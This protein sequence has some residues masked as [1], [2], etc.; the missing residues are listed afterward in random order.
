MPQHL[1][2]AIQHLVSR[3]RKTKSTAVLHP[4]EIL[5]AVTDLSN[6]K[7]GMEAAG[8]R[9]AKGIAEAVKTFAAEHTVEEL[10]NAATRVK[11]VKKNVKKAREN[12]LSFHVDK[13][14]MPAALLRW[15]QRQHLRS[16]DAGQRMS[17]MV[18]DEKFLE[19]ALL[20]PPALSG[21]DDTQA[22][23]AT[24]AFLDATFPDQLREFEE[25]E[26]SI[27]TFTT[28]VDAG[29]KYL[30]ETLKLETDAAFEQ[31]MEES[32]KGLEDDHYNRVM[33]EIEAE[34]RVSMAEHREAFG[35]T[36]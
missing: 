2:D 8:T 25:T 24:R 3:H 10:R 6:L 17:L 30:R 4:D 9:T 20:A 31:F 27:E 32:S 5:E 14:D 26:E 7:A 12:L 15:E 13:D 34:H 21:L 33:T 28:A 1:I 19:A 16:L 18:S 22:Q 35:A 23:L 36:A 29:M 11:I